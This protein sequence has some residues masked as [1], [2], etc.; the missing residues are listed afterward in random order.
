M[1]NTRENIK[2]DYRDG[3][4]GFIIDAD[5]CACYHSMDEGQDECESVVHRKVEGYDR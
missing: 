2:A 4:I 3:W 1:I 5:I